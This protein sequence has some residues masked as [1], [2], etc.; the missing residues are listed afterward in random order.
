MWCIF[1]AY[2]IITT[3]DTA[4]A[5]IHRVIVVVIVIF[6]VIMS[7]IIVPGYYGTFTFWKRPLHRT[8]SMSSKY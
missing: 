1:G 8:T 4:T 3:P 5:Y 2:I 7:I 6:V